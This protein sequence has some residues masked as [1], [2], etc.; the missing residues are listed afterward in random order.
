MIADVSAMAVL[1]CFWLQCQGSFAVR[2]PNIVL[3]VEAYKL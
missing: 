1:R 2:E 3:I